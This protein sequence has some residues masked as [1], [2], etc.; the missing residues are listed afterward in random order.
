MMNKRIVIISVYCFLFLVPDL[1]TG[2]QQENNVLTK[3]EKEQGWQLLFD[4]T[5]TEG[6]RG[7]RIDTITPNWSAVEGEL[8]ADGSKGD[9]ITIEQFADFELALEWKIS[10][11]GNSGVF[12]HVKEGPDFPMVWHTGIEMQVMD[13]QR[14]PMAKK[15]KHSAGSLFDMYAPEKD[16]TKPA[17]EWNQSRIVHKD[18]HVEYWMNGELVNQYQRWTDQWYNDREECLHNKNRKPLW[19]EFKN[20]H[21][22]LQDEGFPVK[23]RNIKIKILK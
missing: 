2:Q 6:W 8:Q 10:K 5:T 18:G 21:I 23:Y 22:A 1:V 13:N 11:G 3:E 20:G 19:G 7:Y 14:N 4:G 12:Y 16:A 15:P 9:I 17:G